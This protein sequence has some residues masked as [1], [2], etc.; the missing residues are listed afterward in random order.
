MIGVDRPTTGWEFLEI[1][2]CFSETGIQ[3]V[4]ETVAKRFANREKDGFY[5]DFMKWKKTENQL[6]VATFRAP[7]EIL[8]PESLDCIFKRDHPGEPV[9][10]EFQII[11]SLC[12]GWIPAGSISK[13]NNHIL[14]LEFKERIPEML[15]PLH[16]EDQFA[17]TAPFTRAR[18]GLCR[19]TDFPGI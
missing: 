7:E 11:H 5:F 18:F 16:V 14:V 15:H 2:S 12:N 6:L 1:D 9:F 4:K 8:L 19:S 3:A 17:P 13:G 10:T